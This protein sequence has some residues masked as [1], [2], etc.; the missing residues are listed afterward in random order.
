[1]EGGKI[2]GLAGLFLLYDEFYRIG[3]AWRDDAAI[4]K[5]MKE[6]RG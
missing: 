6:E 4:C 2:L 5:W 1:M 3:R